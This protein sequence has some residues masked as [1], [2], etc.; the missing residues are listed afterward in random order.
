ML[1][2]TAVSGVLVAACGLI[3]APVPAETPAQT[4]VDRLSDPDQKVREASAVALKNRVDA[5]PW[6][7]RAAR[8][9]D[10]DT[11]RRAADLL[12]LH[13]KQRQEAVAGAI[14]ACVRDGRID[15]LTEW[16]QFWKPKAGED[17]WAVGPRATKAGR[18][19]P[20]G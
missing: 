20:S 4:L 8:A 7:R 12:A 13:E 17:L 2:F 14:D 10:K 16:H 9:S 6:L 15:V 5:L 3:A 1:R 11:A 19:T 18:C